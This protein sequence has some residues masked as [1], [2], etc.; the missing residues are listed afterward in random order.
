[1]RNQKDVVDDYKTTSFLEGQD[2]DD[3]YNL[4]GDIEIAGIMLI[5]II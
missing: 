5:I 4:E 1:M 3:H 2:N